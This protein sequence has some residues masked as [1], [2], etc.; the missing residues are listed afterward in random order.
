MIKIWEKEN[1]KDV[2]IKSKKK[3]YY[4]LFTKKDL[5]KSSLYNNTKF[6]KIKRF[7][8]KNKGN[9]NFYNYSVVKRNKDFEGEIEIKSKKEEEK[10]QIL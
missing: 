8:Y 9:T 2:K 1:V 4:R 3:K 6:N 10:K 5:W 7:K